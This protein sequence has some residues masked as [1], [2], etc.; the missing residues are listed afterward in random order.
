MA[1]LWRSRFAPLAIGALREKQW[2]NE[3]AITLPPTAHL[4]PGNGKTGQSAA[5]PRDLIN[6]PPRRYLPRTP[7]LPRLAI[8]VEAFGSVIGSATIENGCKQLMLRAISGAW[9]RFAPSVTRVFMAIPLI[10]GGTGMGARPTR[11]SPVNFTFRLP[12]ERKPA[13]L[14]VAG[15][16]NAAL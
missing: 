3:R 16:W 8:P 5:R 13:G 2:R 11:Y 9:Q 6:H 15:A 14:V 12:I 1:H 4:W 10:K 7:A